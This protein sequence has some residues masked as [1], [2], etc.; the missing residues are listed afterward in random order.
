MFYNVEIT[1]CSF[2]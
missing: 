1:S 2:Y